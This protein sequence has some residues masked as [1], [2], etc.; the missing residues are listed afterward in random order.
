MT[1]V[2]HYIAAGLITYENHSSEKL[3]RDS[4]ELAVS[5]P[6]TL[7][8]P[9]LD[10]VAPLSV[11]NSENP[12]LIYLARLAPG[13]RPSMKRAL[14]TITEILT[15]G[16]IP[17]ETLP[18]HELRYQHTQAVRTVLAE[19]YAHTTANKALSALRGV[20]KE[21]WRLGAMQAEDYR[22][23]VDVRNVKGNTLPRGRALSTGEIT[24]L[25][26]VCMEDETGAGPRD[27]AILSVL[28]AGGLRR[29]EAIG[30]DL[31]D[32]N[33]EDGAL[34]VR[35]GKGN[36]ARIVYATNGSKD[37]IEAWLSVR[38]AE[39]GPLF[40]RIR[41]GGHLAP[42]RLTPQAI[43]HVLS[44]RRKEAEVKAFSPHDLRRSFISDLLDAGADTPRN[45]L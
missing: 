15:G 29:A 42:E 8:K 34:T 39:P 35:A 28:Y 40:Y 26:H 25:F 18:W 12:V 32:Y 17:V 14:M 3:S 36:K 31:S 13:S 16:A 2:V 43:L 9:I 1:S 37:A 44:K 21:S 11:A 19:R 7:P 45:R 24:A 5:V 33:P 4:R 41:R 22:R 38:G 10:Q 23:A 30:L 27:A 20:L 6:I